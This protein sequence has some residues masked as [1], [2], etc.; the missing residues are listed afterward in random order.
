MPLLDSPTSHPAPFDILKKVFP[1]FCSG[2]NHLLWHPIMSEKSSKQQFF[3]V[4]KIS[5]FNSLSTSIQVNKVCFSSDL[6][7][8]AGPLGMRKRRK[9]K[10]CSEEHYH[11]LK[12]SPGSLKICSE[13]W[14]GKQLPYSKQLYG[15]FLIFSCSGRNA[16]VWNP[17]G[18]VWFCTT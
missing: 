10:E 15:H 13:R 16:A 18:F 8:Q 14:G 6:Q 2:N 5:H 11:H 7:V 1:T 12:S 4:V 17:N 3:E 9:V